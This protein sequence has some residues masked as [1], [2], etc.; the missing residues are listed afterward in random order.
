M[1]TSDSRP[2]LGRIGEDAAA[3]YLQSHGYAILERNFR[4]PL[5][6]VDV[7]ARQGDTL[8]FVEV[9]ARSAN[10]P[11]PPAAS[12]TL[13]KQQQVVRL[14]KHYLATRTRGEWP[15][16]FDVVEVVLASPDQVAEVRLIQGAF[17]ERG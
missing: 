6:E 10:S 7:I 17:G 4:G 5:G 16:R 14:A 8:V 13:R 1:P 9:K 12:V 15:V 2:Q 3:R 11:L